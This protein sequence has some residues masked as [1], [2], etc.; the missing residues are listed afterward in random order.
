MYFPIFYQF[1]RNKNLPSRPF[2][3]LK[4]KPTQVFKT[5]E[6]SITGL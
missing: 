5:S 3:D 4:K 6:H 1:H 2:V